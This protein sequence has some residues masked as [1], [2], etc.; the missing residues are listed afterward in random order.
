MLTRAPLGYFAKRAPLGGADSTPPPPVPNPRT[1]DRSEVGEAAIESSSSVYFE[2]LL[3]IFLKCH[4]SGQGQ[5][6]GQNRHFSPY[7]LLRRD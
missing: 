5:V 1:G 3:K 6:Q 4:M 2:Q 7:R